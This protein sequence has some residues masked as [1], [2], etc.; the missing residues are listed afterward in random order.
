MHKY[1]N[2]EF[3]KFYFFIIIKLNHKSMLTKPINFYKFLY[4]YRPLEIKCNQYLEQIFI[5]QHSDAENEF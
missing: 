1:E 4:H 5:Y 2:D 3:I